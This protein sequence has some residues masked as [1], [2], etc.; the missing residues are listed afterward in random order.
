DRTPRFGHLFYRSMRRRMADLRRTGIG[1]AALAGVL[2]STAP[3]G[4]AAGQQA[5]PASA[6]V[7]ADASPKP[8]PR[9][10]LNRY[11]VGCHSDAQLK[12]GAVPVALDTIDVSDPKTDARVWETVV[13]K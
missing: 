12:R 9:A 4:R 1:A 13:R 11:C 3:T 8:D 2:L 6:A 5:G 7:P 10:L